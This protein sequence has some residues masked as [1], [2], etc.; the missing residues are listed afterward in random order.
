MTPSKFA[1]PAF[2]G[3]LLMTA[4]ATAFAA[5]P[6][7]ATELVAARQAAMKEDGRILKGA[8]ALT[9]DQAIE[10]LRAI[11]ANYAKFPSQFPK[12]SLTDKS[13]AL[14]IIWEQFDQFSAIF[15]KGEDAAAEGIAAVKAGDM[16]KYQ[17]SI[18]VVA[19]TC[20]ECHST[21][22]MKKS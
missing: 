6:M 14:P 8:D 20:K 15:K 17:A 22:R 18:E 9:G 19:S 21:Y 16:E 1:M 12:D 5:A 3:L 7:S 4:V 2:A 10:A 11:E 13:I